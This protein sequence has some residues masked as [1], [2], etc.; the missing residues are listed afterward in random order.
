MTVVTDSR[1]GSLTCKELR[2]MTVNTSFVFGILG[3]IRE[4]LIS[5]THFFPVLG[6]KTVTDATLEFLLDDVRLVGKSG[7]VDVG[8]FNCGSIRLPLL[9]SLNNFCIAAFDGIQEQATTEIKHRKTHDYGHKE[10]PG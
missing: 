7:V 1:S 3:D 10:T 5:F 6:R 4:G 8:L 9:P 2:P